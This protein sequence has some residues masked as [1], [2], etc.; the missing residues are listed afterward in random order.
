[1]NDQS[2]KPITSILD[3][4]LAVRQK[5]VSACAEKTQ[6]AAEMIAASLTKN[7]KLMICGNGGSAADAQ[8]LATEF[9]ATLDHKNPSPALAAIAL[10]TDSS[11]LTAWSNDFGFDSVF[12]RQIDALGKPNDVLLAISTSGNSKNI[13][14][15]AELAKN[16]KINV[17]ALTGETGGKLT[18]FADI[19]LAV[20]SSNTIYIQECHIALGHAM[21][22]YV[23]QLVADC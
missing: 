1:M 2:I 12:S 4:G 19:T 8:H 7:G 20:P 21:T 22:A 17:I 11:F 23:E 18:D 13:I 10:T 15:A 5:L 14:K 16:K 6:K 9:V 3:E